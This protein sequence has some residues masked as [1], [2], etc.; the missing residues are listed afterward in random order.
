MPGVRLPL[1]FWRSGQIFQYLNR[2]DFKQSLLSWSGLKFKQ[3][4]FWILNANSVFLLISLPLYFLYYPTIHLFVSCLF[5][6]SV[7]GSCVPD[8]TAW[9]DLKRDSRWIAR[10]CMNWE[11]LCVLEYIYIYTSLTYEHR[12]AAHMSAHTHYINTQNT[13]MHGL[14][15]QYGDLL[16]VNAALPEDLRT[17]CKEA[18]RF[19]FVRTWWD[20]AS[21]LLNSA[22]NSLVQQL[23]GHCTSKSFILHSLTHRFLIHCVNTANLTVCTKLITPH[24]ALYISV[25]AWESKEASLAGGWREA[26]AFWWWK[27]N[28]RPHFCSSSETG[29]R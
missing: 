13:S 4:L 15:Q 14:T 23:R 7:P 17:T 18:Q 16:G 11:V 12:N 29:Q 25:S 8:T 10:L 21:S 5:L 1:I 6:C 26:L 27:K 9:A 28:L 2:G 19:V 3:N 20:P 22:C 24:G